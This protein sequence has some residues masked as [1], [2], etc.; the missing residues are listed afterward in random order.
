MDISVLCDH[1][2]DCPYGDDEDCCK[3]FI[4]IHLNMKHKVNAGSVGAYC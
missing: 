1:F 4:E 3:I 2:E